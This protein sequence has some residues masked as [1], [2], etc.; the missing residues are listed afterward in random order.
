MIGDSMKK[1]G[2]TLVELLAVIIVLAII[3]LIAI[4]AVGSI[5]NDS[6]EK[7]SKVQ[8]KEIKE[9]AK[10]WAAYNTNLLS[11]EETYYVSVETLINE[12]YISND[13]VTDPNDHENNIE[14]CVAISYS[15]KYSSYQFEYGTCPEEN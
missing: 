2:F 13:K 14:G 8:I 9:S 7:V 11:K 1:D 10:S 3:G 5:I 15:N 12:G 6:K 4:P